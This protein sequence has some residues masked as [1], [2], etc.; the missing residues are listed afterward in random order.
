[1]PNLNLR[2]RLFETRIGYFGPERAGK[3]TNLHSLRLR[4]SEGRSTAISEEGR[5][6]SFEWRPTRPSGLH[7]CALSVR[8]VAAEAA[9]PDEQLEQVL[10]DT[11]GLVVVL[12]SQK[13]ALADNRR[14][15]EV[16]RARL[17]GRADLPIVVQLNKRDAPDAMTEAELVTSLELGS[18]PRLPAIAHEG[19]GVLETVSRMIDEILRKARTLPPAK[20]PEV[21]R[22]A[23]Q[24]EAQLFAALERTLSGALVAEL[25]NAMRGDNERIALALAEVSAV[26]RQ[27]SQALSTL[28]VRVDALSRAQ[29]MGCSRE[30]LTNTAA[31]SEASILERLDLLEADLEAEHNLVAARIHEINAVLVAT[32]QDT[33]ALKETAQAKLES[34]ERLANNALAQTARI[35]PSVRTSIGK[36]GESLTRVEAA[37]DRAEQLIASSEDGPIARVDRLEALVREL[38]AVETAA[39][40]RVEVRL[41]QTARRLD[42]LIE[43]LRKKRGWFR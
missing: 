23:P 29:T 31:R 8:L 34:L 4:E 15:L 7:D 38:A 19:S 17:A 30:D 33:L 14:A 2:D 20:K 1:M 9:P 39:R 6:L 41:E 28:T 13:A 42:E 12:D 18:W 35:E 37:Q 32:R 36:V 11:D 3:S 43:E 10:P 21:A 22:A 40:E 24:G 27:H 25:A 26:Q 5:V 16:L